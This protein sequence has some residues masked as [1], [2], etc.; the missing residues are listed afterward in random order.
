LAAVRRLGE[1]DLRAV[2][3]NGVDSTYF[4]IGGVLIRY[5]N[6]LTLPLAVL[7]VLGTAVAMW[8]A[9]RRGLNLRSVAVSSLTVPVVLVAAVVVGLGAWWLVTLV[10]PDYGGLVFG[11]PY[12]SG[13]VKVGFGLLAL[14]LA[15]MWALWSRRKHGVVTVAVLTVWFAL[16]ALTT[17]I[18]A[19][20]MAYVFTWPAVAG[21]AAIAGTAM[22]PARSP[23]RSV[24]GAALAVPAV[25]LL[26]PIGVLLFDITGIAFSAVPLVVLTLCALAGTA[27]FLESMSRRGIVLGLTTVLVAS[28]AV[29]TVGVLGDDTGPDDPAQVSLVYALDADTGHAQWVSNGAG[30][31]AWLDLHVGG[32]RK[33]VEEGFPNLR[34]PGDCLVGAAKPASLRR[35]DQ[36]VVVWRRRPGSRTR[37][38]FK[39]PARR[40]QSDVSARQVELGFFSRWPAGRRCGSRTADTWQRIAD[41]SRH[42]ADTRC[43]YGSTRESPAER[44]HVGRGF[45]RP[46]LRG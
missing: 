43:A 42:S 33:N 8:F 30:R 39:R 35:A 14:V 21:A 19:P 20:G 17:A 36:T 26:A 28:V 31:N 22:L 10:R 4:T 46:H 32:E 11:D 12:H 18:L 29:T 24:V 15:L 37:R 5:P 25:L 13:L 6:W 3:T 16:L 44:H 34:E 2:V 27:T 7:S 38:W 1:T 9:W 41:P 23:W 45:R 40:G